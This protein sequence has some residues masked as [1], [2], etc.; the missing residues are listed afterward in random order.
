MIGERV[1]LVAVAWTLVDDVALLAIR[2]HKQIEFVGP[3]GP[4]DVRADPMAISAV[5]D[6]A[7]RAEPAEGLLS[8]EC[9]P[10]GSS[11][12]SITEKGSQSRKRS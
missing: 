12:S 6:N 10:T 7:L 4:V 9:M 2:E 3:G 11:L 8:S 1:D 5:I